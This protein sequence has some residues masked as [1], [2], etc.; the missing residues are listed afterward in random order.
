MTKAKDVFM[1]DISKKLDFETM[2]DIYKEG[3]TRIPV[4][5]Q[6][7]DVIKGILNVKDL[8]LVNPDD[9]VSLAAIVAFR[10][11]CHT[12]KLREVLIEVIISRWICCPGVRQ[13]VKIMCACPTN[14]NLGSKRK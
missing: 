12:N 9:E 3:Y 13:A 7:R 4:Y 14:A 1:L 6:A 8:I 2:L 5:E 10:C 11:V